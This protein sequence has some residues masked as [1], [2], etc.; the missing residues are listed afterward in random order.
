[1]K[2]ALFK[3]IFVM[4][5]FYAFFIQPIKF[6][7]GFYS[8]VNNSHINFRKIKIKKTMCMY[9]VYVKYVRNIKEK[10]L[11][12]L[13]FECVGQLCNFILFLNSRNWYDL[14]QQNFAVNSLFYNDIFYFLVW[15]FLP[16]FQF[17]RQNLQ[18]LQNIPCERMMQSHLRFVH[19][20]FHNHL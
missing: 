5:L 4:F 14:H 19:Y 13:Y 8:K 9:I 18:W 6:L 16:S 1:M 15:N 11:V 3:F 12:K 10:I 20:N 7:L 17:Q 2:Y